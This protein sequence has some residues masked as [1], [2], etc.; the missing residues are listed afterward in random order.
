MRFNIIS[1]NC[2]DVP[3]LNS[4]RHYRIKLLIE[5]LIAVNPDV[6]CLQELTFPD[7]RKIAIRRLTSAGY[8]IF[9]SRYLL[10]FNQGG[11]LIASKYP[12]SSVR[13]VTFSN[14]G[15]IT[16][17]Q[18]VDRAIAK[19]YQ[20]VK[21]R[22]DGKTLHVVNTHL[23]CVYRETDTKQMNTH[24]KQLI[25]LSRAVKALQGDV[26][27]TGDLSEPTNSSTNINDFLHATGLVDLT[28]AISQNR[29][30]LKNTNV[31]Y[32]NN[33]F[34]ASMKGGKYDY[35][36]TTSRFQQNMR[37]VELIGVETVSVGSKKQHLSDHY[38]IKVEIEI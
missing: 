3:L 7:T 14:K 31:M 5:N 38:G 29:V 32:Q 27:L 34:N 17:M 35:I 19:G 20:L 13:Y 26:I 30:D 16:S 12:I 28:R 8:K 37:L 11:L 6:I 22:V 21:I 2:F 36:L 1:Q 25:Q 10:G 9:S 18:V 4:K 23:Y 15:N 33:K 24:R